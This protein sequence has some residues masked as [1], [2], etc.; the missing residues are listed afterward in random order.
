MNG[1]YNQLSSAPEI[2][3]PVG[4]MPVYPNVKDDKFLFDPLIIEAFENNFQR[5]TKT[6]QHFEIALQEEL[7]NPILAYMKMLKIDV[8]HN[9][10]SSDNTQKSYIGL[11]DFIN[12]QR[13]TF[14]QKYKNFLHSS[15]YEPAM[16]FLEYQIRHHVFFT[17]REFFD[18]ELKKY[19]E[20]LSEITDLRREQVAD[21]CCIMACAGWLPWENLVTIFN[22]CYAPGDGQC[23]GAELGNNNLKNKGDYNCW[24]P[25]GSIKSLFAHAQKTE[26]TIQEL[27][28]HLLD[29][30]PAPGRQVMQ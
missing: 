23:C 29:I 9:V 30:K 19:Q 21:W 5:L 22:C 8:K 3:A 17:H 1:R 14:K 6:A 15:S 13:M 12:N 28:T 18:Q 7:L 10:S 2:V 27:K 4:G 11:L 26:T 20:G 25:Y 24:A 16:E